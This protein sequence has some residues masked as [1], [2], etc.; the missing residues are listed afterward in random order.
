MSRRGY[1]QY[2]GLARALELVGE[3]W[4]LLIIRDLSVRPRRYTDLLDGLPGI[5]TNVL[6]TRLKELEQS[7]II[8]RRIAPAP[9]R[10]VLYALTPAG[11][12]LEPA[13]LSLSRWGATQLDDPRPGEIVTPES[14]TNGLRALF[15][16]DAAA[17][18]TASWE[19]HVADIVLHLIVTDGKL[20]AGVGPAPGKPDL[21]MTFQPDGAPSF[22]ALIQAARR[23]LVELDGRREL[24]QTF[25]NV[26]ARPQP[27]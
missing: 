12:A 17:R 26:F 15:N 24:L 8:E 23:G 2:C 14:A 13:I 21:V 6:S 22:L 3:R 27:A 18:L 5:P 7:D 20:D 1:K 19:I 11:H 4:A 9:Q 16:P 25:T 10:G